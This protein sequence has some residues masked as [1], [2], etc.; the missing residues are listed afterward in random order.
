MFAL[1]ATY[2]DTQIQLLELLRETIFIR[3]LIVKLLDAVFTAKS[4][5]QCIEIRERCGVIEG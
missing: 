2:G 1:I 3:L 4:S 5:D